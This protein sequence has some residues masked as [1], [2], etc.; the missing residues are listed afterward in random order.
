MKK[1]TITPLCLLGWLF[2]C[3]TGTGAAADKA[4]EEKIVALEK[5][6]WEAIK[7]KD[8]NT[9]SSLMTE[10]FVEVGDMGIRGKSEAIQDLKSNL[11]LTDY[12]MEEAKVLELSKDAALV[13]YRL[14][15]KGSYQGQNLPPKTNCSATYARRGGK[16][17]NTSFQ[18]TVAR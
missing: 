18:Q 6:G 7:K 14:S 16:W 15:Q 1:W 3:F 13:T 2:L 17:L 5:Q 11:I 8:W 12:T 4:L 9:L 10:D